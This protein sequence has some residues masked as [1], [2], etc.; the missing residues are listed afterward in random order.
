MGHV[1][2]GVLPKTRPWREVVALLYEAP[3]DVAAVASA[4][5][6]A[7]EKELDRFGAGLPVAYGFW[8]LTRLTMASRGDFAAE[9]DA[10]GLPS[11]STLSATAFSAGL[12][13]HLRQTMGVRAAAFGHFT[14]LAS[15][16]LH[17]T[18]AETIGQQG[19]GLFGSTVH[20][21]QHAFAQYSSGDQFANLARRYFG[22][23]LART[24]KSFLDREVPRQLGQPGG[25]LNSIADRMAFDKAVGT[26]CRESA[27]IVHDF[28]RDWYGKAKWQTEGDIDFARAADFTGVAM[29][30]LR[31]ELRVGTK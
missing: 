8:L 12:G 5:A 31:S 20:D 3:H 17:K 13:D 25:Q 18:L 11:D 24:V 27:F 26:Y 14:E 19:A 30:K 4:V 16:S 28:A 1:R 2:L 7:A 29:Q 22:D 9:L 15:L 6:V 21:V 10:L 23:L